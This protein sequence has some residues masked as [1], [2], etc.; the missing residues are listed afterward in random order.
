MRWLGNLRHAQHRLIEI[1]RFRRR[2]RVDDER[3][4]WLVHARVT[5]RAHFIVLNSLGSATGVINARSADTTTAA[6]C[7]TTR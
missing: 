3:R 6:A 5:S 7:V 4:R 2:D 1:G